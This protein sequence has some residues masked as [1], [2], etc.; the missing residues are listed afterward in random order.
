MCYLFAAVT[1]LQNSQ[2]QVRT[3]ELKLE[4]NEKHKILPI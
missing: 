2:Y 4:G 1:F 3:L